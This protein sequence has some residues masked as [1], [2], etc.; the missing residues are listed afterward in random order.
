MFCVREPKHHK[1]LHEVS[2]CKQPWWE[3]DREPNLQ[4][5]CQHSFFFNPKSDS[6]SSSSHAHDANLGSTRGNKSLSSPS[7]KIEMRISD[8]SNSE[9]PQRES[10]PFLSRPLLVSHYHQPWWRWM[11]GSVFS[12]LKKGKFIVF[13]YFSHRTG[14]KY[15][16]LSTSSFL[17]QVKHEWINWK[18]EKEGKPSQ[19]GKKGNGQIVL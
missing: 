6:C 3:W 14:T 10:G 8:I 15:S 19:F 9:D 5:H 16:P 2:Q 12:R 18:T 4:Y 11:E 13:L 1:W 17:F 7:P